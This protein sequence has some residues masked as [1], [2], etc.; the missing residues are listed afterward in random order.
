MLVFIEIEIIQAYITEYNIR[1]QHIRMSSENFVL[2]PNDN[3]T[4]G[5]RNPIAYM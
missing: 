3:W 1:N 5:F 4:G 2:F